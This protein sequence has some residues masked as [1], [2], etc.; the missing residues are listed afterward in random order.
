MSHGDSR[1][2]RPSSV[3]DACV[4]RGEVR[5]LGSCGGPGRLDESTLEPCRTVAGSMRSALAGGLMTGRSDAGP[6]T[7]MRSRWEAA[8][9]DAHLG[10]HGFGG[11]SRD[12]TDRSD[13]G[14]RGLKRDEQGGDLGGECWRWTGRG[15][16]C[17]RSPVGRR[18]RDGARSVP[19]SASWSWGILA[20]ITALGH[21]GQNLRDH[22]P[23]RSS[24]R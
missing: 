18:P 15:S 17:A 8:H 20:R 6:G 4:L 9:V 7:E 24:L 21:L 22:V 19:D 12:A 11:R 2:V 23:R 14:D 10:H 1:L 3:C 16:R 13:D 5:A